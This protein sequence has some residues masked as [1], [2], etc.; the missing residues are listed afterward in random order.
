M[1]IYIYIQ[2]DMA[3][4]FVVDEFLSGDAAAAVAD[5][6]VRGEDLTSSPVKH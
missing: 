6:M 4:V 5:A 2:G 3:G 1:Y